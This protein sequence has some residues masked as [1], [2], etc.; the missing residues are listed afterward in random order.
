MCGIVGYASRSVPV[1]RARV[2]AQRDSLT[3]RGPDDQGSWLATDCTAALGHRRLS[4]IDLSPAGRQPMV[5]STGEL[6]IVFNGEIFNFRDLRH[7]LEHLGHRFRT[8]TDTEVLLAAY[9]EWGDDFLRYLNGQFAIGLYDAVKRRML[10]ARDRAG[11]KPLFYRH[12]AETLSF[13]SELKALMADPTMPRVIDPAALNWYLTYGYVPGDL[14][15]LRGVH[16]LPAA[17]ALSYDIASDAVRLWRYWGLPTPASDAE[18][19]SDAQWSDELEALLEDSV[20]RQLVADVPVGILLSGG[21][22]SS[23]VT[24]LAARVSATP[25]K[26]FTIAFP[27]HGSYDESPFARLV[28]EHFG[29]DH[30]ELV[31]EPATADLLPML[32]RQYDEPMADSSMLPTYLVSRLI[33]E[34]ATVALGGDGGDELFG[35]YMHHSWIQSQERLRALIPR[36]IRRVAHHLVQN[37]VPVGVKGRNFLLGYTSD[38]GE[39]IARYGMFFD[40]HMRQ[41][42]LAS[43]RS[44]FADDT[45]EMVKG[46]AFADR[47]PLWRTTAVDFSGYLTDDIL[48]K[49]DRA[50]MLTSL[51]VRAPWLDYRI[52]ELAFGRVPDRLRATARERKILPRRLAARIL[53]SALDLNR[54]QGFSIPLHR[55]FKGPWG[56]M[57][58]SVLSEADPALFDRRAIEQLLAAQRRGLSNTHRLFALTLFEL[59]RREY[60]VA[61]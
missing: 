53:P 60:G 7:D 42:L 33:R 21:V 23:L 40:Q 41:Q 11:E 8:K 3:H 15:I 57:F 35:G 6:E 4:I 2:E 12:A 17:H 36:P 54:K 43:G 49:V 25:V 26:T 29:T 31:A 44:A 34:H 52:I 59:W 14:C 16:K 48:V 24:A 47:T 46:S 10:L 37:L 27:G 20:R 61:M 38:L 18:E 39:S 5:D 9:R 56:T 22:D 58:E 13:A 32:A 28:A 55:W 30:T 19:L 51:E 1:D 45:P 50:S